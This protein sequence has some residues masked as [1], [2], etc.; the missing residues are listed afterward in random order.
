MGGKVS[1]FLNFLLTGCGAGYGYYVVGK[2]HVY[3]VDIKILIF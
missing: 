3:M 1:D 2:A